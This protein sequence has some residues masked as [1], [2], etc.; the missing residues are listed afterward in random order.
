MLPEATPTPPSESTEPAPTSTG[1]VGAQAAAMEASDRGVNKTSE[2]ER[3]TGKARRDPGILLE[4]LKLAA[5][6]D[7]GPDAGGRYRPPTTTETTERATA[8]LKWMQDND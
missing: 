8:Y 1:V 7:V 5:E 4:L 3:E 2:T 6:N